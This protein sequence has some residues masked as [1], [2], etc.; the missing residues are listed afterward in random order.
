MKKYVFV[1]G[2]PGS[3]WGRPEHM[4]T[5]TTGIVDKSNFHPYLV[6]N[7]ENGTNHIHKFYGP[8]QQ[9]G[10]RFD[11]LHLMGPDAVIHEIDRSFD[12]SDIRPLRFIRCHWFSYQLDWIKENL[13]Q[14]DIMLVF[15][16]AQAA[17]NWWHKSGG[18]NITYPNYRWYA[19]SENMW[20]QINIENEY[21]L[22][23]MYENK[24]KMT[25]STVEL[26]EWI[27]LYWPELVQYLAPDIDWES[28][29]KPEQDYSVCPVLYT[30]KESPT[31]KEC[32]D[33]RSI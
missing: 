2:V 32:L 11:A 27:K 1:T 17:Y 6:D 25:H 14:V 23:F 7:A 19:T 15:R 8:Y 33:G 28:M 12:P 5:R 30:G 16:E 24:L 18:W 10:E 20:R 31:I 22:K 21:M 13:P 4:I 3:A 9:H 29:R 26:D